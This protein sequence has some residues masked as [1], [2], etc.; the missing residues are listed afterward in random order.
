MTVWFLF[1]EMC[2]CDRNEV[3]EC[4]F[5]PDMLAYF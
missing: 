2:I 1:G 5:N 4:F 3:M